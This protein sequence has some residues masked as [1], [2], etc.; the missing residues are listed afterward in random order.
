M[1]ALNFMEDILG[2]TGDY[3]RECYANRGALSVNSK[4]HANDFLTT[5][6]IK[7]QKQLILEILKTFPDDAILAEES[8][9]N[10]YPDTVPERCWAIDPIDGTQN[11][12]RGLFPAFGV[13]L[14][15]IERGVIVAGGIYMPIQDDLFL[16]ASGMGAVKN[17]KAL[18]VTGI[19]ELAMARVDI[20]FNGPINRKE[21]IKRAGGILL[22]AGQIRSNACSVVGFCSVASG[23]DDVYMVLGINT[24]DIAAGLILVTEA[25]G[26]VSRFDGSPVNPFDGGKDV[27]VS[28]GVLHDLCLKEIESA[29]TNR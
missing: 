18:K 7:V 23:E 11:F 3:I 29:M 6:D 22:K 25:G 21:I 28:N 20:D 10:I 24:W 4:A 12:L 19:S 17:N 13:S 14:A 8:G 1:S 15:L 2:K 26:K 9:L 16:A 27:L 5:V